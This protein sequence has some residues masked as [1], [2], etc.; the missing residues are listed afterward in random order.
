MCIRDRQKAHDEVLAETQRIFND[1]ENNVVVDYIV[2]GDYI[3]FINKFKNAF[4]DKLVIK[5]LMPEEKELVKRDKERE[6]WTAGPEHIQ[7]VINELNS[8]KAVVG[9]ENY[10]NTTF[11]TPEE[12]FQKYFELYET[13]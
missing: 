5:I 9:E 4:G 2:F 11:Q 10:I 1:G 3:N 6:C 12:T 8:I 7:R 13:N